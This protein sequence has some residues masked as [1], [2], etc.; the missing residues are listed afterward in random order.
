MNKAIEVLKE[1]KAEVVRLMRVWKKDKTEEGKQILIRLKEE[2][3]QYYEA[4]K[5][6]KE[7]DKM[8]TVIGLWATDRPDLVGDPENVMFQ[9]K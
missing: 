4:L 2:D 7:P 9:I 5:K 3:K 6:L 8:H 1:N